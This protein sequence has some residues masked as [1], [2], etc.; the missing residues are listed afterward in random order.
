MA[1]H[2]MGIIRLCSKFRLKVRLAAESIDIVPTVLKTTM[3]VTDNIQLL[4]TFSLCVVSS[5]VQ[6]GTDVKAV[7]CLNVLCQL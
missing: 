3:I 5:S 7:C 4:K 6:Y 1:T 2:A